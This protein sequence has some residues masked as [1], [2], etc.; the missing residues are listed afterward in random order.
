MRYDITVTTIMFLG[1]SPHFTDMLRFYDVGETV[2]TFMADSCRSV[3]MTLIK[4]PEDESETAYTLQYRTEV[5]QAGTDIIVSDSK[6]IT[7]PSMDRH[8]ATLFKDLA[9]EELKTTVD[10]IN[11]DLY[12]GPLATKPRNGWLYLLKM[13][14]ER[15]K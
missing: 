10:L 8:G 4:L 3:L 11:A 5:R 6:T 2:K 1:K 7:F 13:W 9:L 12:E 14:W 15:F